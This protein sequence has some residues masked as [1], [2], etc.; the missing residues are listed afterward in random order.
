MVDDQNDLAYYQQVAGFDTSIKYFD[1]TGPVNEAI[2]IYDGSTQD[3]RDYLKV[4]LRE[5]G[6]TFDLY[7]LLSS[8]NLSSLTYI[9]YRLPLSNQTDIKITYTDASISSSQP[10][11]SMLIQYYKGTRFETW[12]NSESYILGDIV[13]ASNNRWYRCVSANTN[14]EPPNGTYWE[15]YPGEKLIGDTYYAFNREIRANPSYLPNS[16]EIYAYAQY[17]LRQNTNIND[18]PDSENY[19]NIIGKLASPLCYFVGDTLW[20]NPGVWFENFDPNIT[21]SIVLQPIT[22]ASPGTN[23]LDSEGV[24]KNYSSKTFPYVAAGNIV[25]IQYYKMTQMQNI[26]FI[27]L[28]QEETNM[29]HHLQLL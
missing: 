21:N 20:G 18:D 27:F 7:N 6:K 14:Q 11:T 9:A 29:I 24:P 17:K 15:S 10:F 28:M 5:Q 3:Y 1:K 23:G 8:Q 4:F 12:S 16:Q 2:Q 13:Q 19:G 25:L 22:A 26:G